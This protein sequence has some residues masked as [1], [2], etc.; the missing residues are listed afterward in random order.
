MLPNSRK[1]LIAAVV[2]CL[3]AGGT[4]YFNWWSRNHL[5]PLHPICITGGANF[6]DVVSPLKP[7]VNRIFLDFFGEYPDVRPVE[8][9]I[10]RLF[11]TYKNWILYREWIWIWTNRFFD[12]NIYFLINKFNT[13]RNYCSDWQYELIDRT[14]ADR[15]LFHSPLYIEVLL[16]EAFIFD[17]DNNKSYS[18]YMIVFITAGTVLFFLLELLI[19]LSNKKNKNGN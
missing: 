7:E 1:R 11:I 9:D 12:K 3:L 8:T 2:F 17:I 13:D 15:D 5:V 19:W 14:N 16:A 18:W 4:G 10:P 6:F